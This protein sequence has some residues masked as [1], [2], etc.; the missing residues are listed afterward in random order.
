MPN[1]PLSTKAKTHLAHAMRWPP[2]RGLLRVAVQL[3]APKH[4]VGVGVVLLDDHGRVLL[5]KHVFHPTTP[6]GL[7]GGW[8]DRGE[9]PLARAKRELREETGVTTA[10]FGSLVHLRHEPQPNHIAIAYVAHLSARTS[11][12]PPTLTLSNEITAARWFPATEIP[13]PFSPF[14]REAISAALKSDKPHTQP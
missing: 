13:R 10:V 1:L 3:F 11:P 8:L 12:T 5:L 6:W 2:L 9:D 7:P 4:R 14:G